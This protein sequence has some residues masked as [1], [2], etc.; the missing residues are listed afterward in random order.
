MKKSGFLREIRFIY[1]DARN[2]EIR[3][4]NLRS[5]LLLD[6]FDGYYDLINMIVTPIANAVASAIMGVITEVEKHEENDSD[7]G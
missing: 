1:K 5:Q 4:A 3:I 2:L 7:P 6:G